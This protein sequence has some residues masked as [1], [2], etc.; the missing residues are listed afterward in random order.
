[1][2]EHEDNQTAVSETTLD[3]ALEH[4]LPVGGQAVV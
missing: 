3:T 1:V 4:A 2:S